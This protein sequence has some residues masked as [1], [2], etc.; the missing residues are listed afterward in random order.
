MFKKIVMGTLLFGGMIGI[1][2]NPASATPIHSTSE[3]KSLDRDGLYSTFSPWQYL[4]QTSRELHI[5]TNDPEILV[6][7]LAKEA[8]FYAD[9]L[10]TVCS[11]ILNAQVKV[12]Y[13]TSKEW[14]RMQDGNYVFKHEI[15]FYRDKERTQLI[16]E[17]ES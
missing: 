12:V 15:K 16:T 10:F 6:A 4:G 14:V 1:Y 3:V 7:E 2:C 5:N 13:W 11:T 9:E 17:M 8:P